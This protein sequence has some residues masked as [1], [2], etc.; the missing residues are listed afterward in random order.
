LNQLYDILNRSGLEHSGRQAMHD[1]SKVVRGR[2]PG[3]I[4]EEKCPAEALQI[5]AK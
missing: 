2:L 3:S 4:I 1:V 5:I